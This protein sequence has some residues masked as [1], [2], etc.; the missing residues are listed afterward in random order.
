MTACSWC[1]VGTAAGSRG[2]VVVSAADS[3]VKAHSPQFADSTVYRRSGGG[4]WREVRAGLPEP[5]GTVRP[6]LATNA[7]ERGVFYAASNRGL[8]RSG[9]GGVGWEPVL[10]PL[11]DRYRGQSPH[12]I[13]VTP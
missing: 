7:E 8:F 11:P 1:G 13:V 4:P 3:P 10:A 6:L 2:S 5:E 9:D 12:A